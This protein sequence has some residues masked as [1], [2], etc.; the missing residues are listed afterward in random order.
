MNFSKKINTFITLTFLIIVFFTFNTPRVF[1]DFIEQSGYCSK[2][3]IDS[4]IQER[5]ERYDDVYNLTNQINFQF[6]VAPEDKDKVFTI[7]QGGLVVSNVARGGNDFIPLDG[8]ITAVISKRYTNHTLWD[9]GVTRTVSVLKSGTEGPYC[10]FDYTVK[11]GSQVIGNPIDQ[12]IHNTAFKNCQLNITSEEDP[13]RTDSKTGEKLRF[14]DKTKITINAEN[15]PV[16]LRGTGV[17]TFGAILGKYTVGNVYYTIRVINP[18]G[19]WK[20][21]GENGTPDDDFFISPKNANLGDISITIQNPFN[22]QLDAS[23]TPLRYQVEL[24]RR[25]YNQHDLRSGPGPA[26]NNPFIETRCSNSF[27]INNTSGGNSED[28]IPA[29][30]NQD[31]RVKVL[32]LCSNVDPS[33]ID[34]CKDCVDN[35]YIWTAVGCIKTDISGFVGSFFKIGL[36]IAGGIALLFIIYGGFVVLTS[37]GN[38][39]QIQH[40]REMLTSAIAGLLLIIFSVFIFNLISNDILKIPFDELNQPADPNKNIYSLEQTFPTSVGQP[41][42][43]GT[44]MS[45]SLTHP[46]GVPLGLEYAIVNSQNKEV[47][48]QALQIINNDV[49][50]TSITTAPLD[51]PPDN[52]RVEIFPSV[53]SND[54]S[55]CTHTVQSPLASLSFTIAEANFNINRISP[56][57]TQT[58]PRLSSVTFQVSGPPLQ[59]TLGYV[60]TSSAGEVIGSLCRP[61]VYSSVNQSSE[62]VTTE[63]LDLN[64]NEYFI[65][66]YE[67]ILTD[68]GECGYNP[69][70]TPLAT[71]S[72]R[73]TP[74]NC[75]NIV[76]GSCPTNFNQCPEPKTWDCCKDV[77][78]CNLPP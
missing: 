1:A 49:G 76:T 71:H 39:E 74:E 78:L 23:G 32:K 65:K 30:E 70:A 43:R 3:L 73:I 22:Q 2:I 57:A 66:V 68:Q 50:K 46:K 44:S 42:N 67:V 77:S 9:V 20:E 7:R 54:R 6:N 47:N 61:I 8:V 64:P 40:G 51:I 4:S 38:P 27:V 48:C 16:R 5:D 18:D 33:R 10:T 12:Y 69:S 24:M 56:P 41:V 75:V 45:F 35:F 31:A 11:D 29:G 59:R 52:Y 36:G 21:F 26:L 72:V 17:L 53:D 37:A 62:Q 28:A 19:T 14:T 60:I 55:K 25:L 34:Q 58:V 63:L 15:V 13:T